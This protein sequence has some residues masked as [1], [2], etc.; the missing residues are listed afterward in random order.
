MR[1]MSLITNN[2]YAHLRLFFQGMTTD[3]CIEPC[4]KFGRLFPSR[5]EGSI[6][7]LGAITNLKAKGLIK[8]ETIEHFGLEYKRYAIS[9]FG[10]EIFERYSNDHSK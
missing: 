5:P 6:I 10:K 2:N 8:K 9:D 3:L 1:V 4:N 7:T